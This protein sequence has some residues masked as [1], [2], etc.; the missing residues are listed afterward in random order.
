MTPTFIC[1]GTLPSEVGPAKC[2][3]ILASVPVV[4]N[5]HAASRGSFNLSNPD[6]VPLRNVLRE[7]GGRGAAD[8]P[9]PGSLAPPP[10]PG[11]ARRESRDPAPPRRRQPPGLAR[12]LR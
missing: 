7:I 4:A 6:L 8:P 1:R 10:G 3:A 5:T 2:A 9:G 11:V 12:Q